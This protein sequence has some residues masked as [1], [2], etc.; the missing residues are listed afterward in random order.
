MENDTLV[1]SNP[2]KETMPGFARFADKAV[3][4]LFFTVFGGILALLLIFSSKWHYLK[5]NFDLPNF[6]L[7]ILGLVFAA[8]FCFVLHKVSLFLTNRRKLSPWKYLDR[9]SLF[10]AVSLLFGIQMIIALCIM[11]RTGWDAG[12]LQDFAY[13]K[14]T[15]QQPNFNDYFSM[16][17]NNLLLTWVFTQ[18]M[19]LCLGVLQ[20]AD[21]YVFLL[22]LIALNSIIS[23]VTSL[24][25]FRSVHLLTGNRVLSW[26]AWWVYALVVG[27]SPWF[28][29]PYS[30]TTGILF[31]ILLF[32]LYIRPFRKEM[33]R[34]PLIAAC[35]YIGFRIKPTSA[36][37]FI[38]ILLVEIISLF[39]RSTNWKKVL[40]ST[41]TILATIVVLQIGYAALLS[42]A[43][44][45]TLDKERE[46]GP[47]HFVKMGLN[48]QTD[49]V[50]FHDDV[51]FTKTFPTKS[52]QNAANLQVIQDRLNSY[53]RLGTPLFLLRKALV[54]FNN[55]SFAWTQEGSFFIHSYSRNNPL[56]SLLKSYFLP[57]G[58][59]YHL[60]LT[61]S[62]MLWL[63]VL[64]GTFLF[65]FQ[66]RRGTIQQSKQ[67]MV[68]RLTLI[69]LVMYV[70]LFEARARYLY[71]SLPIF[72]LACVLGFYSLYQ[73]LFKKAIQ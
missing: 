68:I 53:G 14:A 62:Q 34:W 35:F 40:I 24:L 39:S 31:P 32:Y 54:N 16:Y 71:T 10:I 6:W 73:R 23:C 33:L 8:A 67:T 22:L 2:R 43:L 19:S 55:G 28:L 41:S 59:L 20:S 60:F 37:P 9:W 26:A 51:L 61:F 56:A 64:A 65:S 29:I 18:V 5:V 42:P 45:I 21:Y 3:Q 69:G 12:A 1:E 52:E 58:S 38:A 30:D 49:G 13:M 47:L 44:G 17:P 46:I 25:L 7:L 4:I 63:T 15:N 36:I 48:P 72:I 57:D 27:L 50:Y 70:M 66:G 11:F